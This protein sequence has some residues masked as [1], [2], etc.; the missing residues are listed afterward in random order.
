MNIFKRFFT[1]IDYKK[2]N[3]KIESIAQKNREFNEN[4]KKL[5]FGKHKDDESKSQIISQIKKDIKNQEALFV[6]VAN[7]FNNIELQK[8]EYAKISMNEKEQEILTEFEQYQKELLS[9]EDETTTKINELLVIYKK[10]RSLENL[11]DKDYEENILLL[12]DEE[13]VKYKEIHKLTRQVNNII[14]GLTT[15]L[16][17]FDKFLIKTFVGYFGGLLIHFC[18]GTFLFGIVGLLS[19]FDPE[20][21]SDFDKLLATTLKFSGLAG[22]IYTINAKNNKLLNKLLSKIQ[23]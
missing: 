3:N 9:I 10:E 8:Q 19:G 7:E 14:E 12:F 20:T 16:K 1:R 6:S 4:K 21:M 17:K 18:A 11:P 23:I 5:Y 13:R 22:A 2:S 15:T